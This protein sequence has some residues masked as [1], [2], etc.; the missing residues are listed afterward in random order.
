M[1]SRKALERFFDK[2]IFLEIFVKV[3][4]DWRNSSRELDSF[5]Y[6]DI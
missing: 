1:E 3:D 6:N 4:K 5:G 2:S